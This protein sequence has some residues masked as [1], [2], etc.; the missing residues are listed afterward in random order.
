MSPVLLATC[1]K[2]PENKKLL[3]LL[4]MFDALRFILLGR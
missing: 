1:L 3:T 4:L 2:Y